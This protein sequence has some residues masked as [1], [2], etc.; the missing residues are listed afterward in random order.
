MIQ[1][2]PL[3]PER[4]STVAGQVDS[5]YFFLVGVSGFFATAIALLIV[6]FSVRYRRRETRELAPTSAG[7]LPL[8]IAWTVIPFLIAMFIFVWAASLFV[9]MRR[10][11]DNALQVYV[12][13]RRW[14]WKVQHLE[15]RREIDELHVPI[16]R[17][18][19]LTMTSEDV[20]HDFFVPAFRVK[21]DVV[22]GRYTTM[23]FEATKAGTYHLFCA[24]Y[25]GTQHS[26]MIGQVIAME[27]ADYQ[28][29]L[30]G[31]TGGAATGVSMAEAGRDLFVQLG[32]ETCHKTGDQGRGPSLAGIAGTRVELADGGAVVA[33]DSYLRESILDSQAKV[34]RGFQP[35]MPTYK[36]LV[37]EDQLVQLIE[38]IK[39]LGS[40]ARVA[41][42]A[43]APS[44]G[45]RE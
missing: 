18:I 44:A 45:G 16:G 22:P 5:L 11:P 30:A 9:S 37:S 41:S 26:H 12:V 20:I 4:A 25:C 34:V 1:N 32:C 2:L 7:A 8:E 38:Y 31:A 15:G 13:G 40:P 10:A 27:P 23:W 24:E 42:A 17:P 36:G 6:F 28:A 29:W 19:L 33:D 21:Q 14:M 3:F 43:G 35:I 39:S